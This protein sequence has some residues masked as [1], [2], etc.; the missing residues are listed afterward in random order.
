M[1][2]TMKENSLKQE[3]KNDWEARHP[4]ETSPQIPRTAEEQAGA[5]SPV[6]GPTIVTT[7][8]RHVRTITTTGHITETIAEDSEPSPVSSPG[9]NKTNHKII[10]QQQQTADHQHNE[11]TSHYQE[12]SYIHLP[13]DNN[14]TDSN[15]HQQVVYSNNGDEL[16]VE[17]QNSDGH[18]ITLS[19]KEPPKY[20]TAER[21]EVER[22]YVYSDT[23]DGRKVPMLVQVQRMQEDLRRQQQHHHHHHH[24]HPQSHRFSPHEN[25]QV[26][27]RYESPS[28]ED[29]EP[30]VSMSQSGSTVLGSPASYSTPVEVARTTQHQLVPTGYSEAAIKYDVAAAVAAAASESI[31]TSSTYTTLETV[32]LPPSQAVQYAQYVPDS[33]QHGNSYGYAKPEITYLNYSGGHSNRNSE[34]EAP[35]GVY[36]KSDPTLSSSS[37]IGSGRTTQLYH[38][39]P[40]SPGSQVTIYGSAGTPTFQYVKQTGE[41]FWQP[42]GSASPPTLEYVQGY[43]GVAT[44]SATDSAGLMYNGGGYVTTSNG[45]SPWASL[46]DE[47]FDGSVMTETKECVNCAANMTTLWRRDGTGHFLCNTCKIYNKPNGANRATMRYNSKMKQTI[48]ASG[49]R[50]GIQCA[51]CNTSN[52]TLWRRNNNGE[53]VCNACGLYYKL[54]NVNRPMSM[55]KDGIQTRKR[56]PKNHSGMSGVLAGPSAGLNKS[57][58]KQNLL[59]D[60]KLHLNMLTNRGGSV[61]RVEDDYMNS[62]TT[63]LGH[64]HSPITLPT[65]AVLNRQTNLTVPPLEPITINKS[66]GDLTVITSTSL[67][68]NIDRS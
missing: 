28:S 63:Q 8:R 60:S 56:K 49:R 53:P 11:Q 58:M 39:Q 27:S 47:A 38:E 12:Q 34:V 29:F 14:S 16:Q 30:S 4:E 25:G 33:F 5:G 57:E 62:I 54:H 65:A 26:N 6:N 23:T 18:P 43:P 17:T 32:P 3:T 24:H 42:A 67:A 61:E 46:Q 2:D 19:L 45:S 15:Q 7:T 9:E 51:N 36:I 55:K 59:V 68:T 66:S 52:T 20:I 64:A 40:G 21:S 37:L 44:I 50:A 48:A 31:K 13:A 1:P 35:S 10:H 41:T 22:V